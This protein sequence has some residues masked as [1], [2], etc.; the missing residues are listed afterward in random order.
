M[1]GDVGPPEQAGAA[2]LEAL[3]QQLTEARA[4]VERLQR[5]AADAAASAQEALAEAAGLRDSLRLS[6]SEIAT[7]ATE[8]ASLREQLD[9]AT[10]RL[11]ATAERYR[12]LVVRAEPSLPADLITGD[13]VDAIDASAASAREIVARVRARIDDEA[14]SRRIPAGSPARGAP[15]LSGMSP[16]Q[17]IRYGLAQRAS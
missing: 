13:D 11:R 16:E 6:N 2:E 8:A 14:Q 3:Q 1:D 10:G 9:A 15:D 12:D 7:A 4:E 17:K 5:E